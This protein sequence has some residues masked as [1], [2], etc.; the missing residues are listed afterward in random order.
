MPLLE[1][2]AE[3]LAR[4][5]SGW[6][7]LLKATTPF[8]SPYLA[9]LM[10]DEPQPE[11]MEDWWQQSLTN[12]LF[13]E[14][15]VSG[16]TLPGDVYSGEVDPRSDET[17]RRA[18]DFAGLAP[19][20]G[21]VAGGR[22]AVAGANKLFGG[23][24]G[25]FTTQ[26]DDPIMAEMEML[27][28]Q[29]SEPMDEVPFISGHSEYDKLIAA[30]MKEN[31]GIDLPV[32]QNLG[33][34]ALE[35]LDII[36]PSFIEGM[37]KHGVDMNL[38]KKQ[39]YGESDEWLG[40]VDEAG[41]ML[42]DPYALAASAGISES[43]VKKLED[44]LTPPDQDLILPITGDPAKDAAAA[45]FL[46]NQTAW[47]PEQKA[48]VVNSWTDAQW[49]SVFELTGMKSK[50]DLLKPKPL[51]TEKFPWLAAPA[52]PTFNPSL[53]RFSPEWGA[54][55]R[56]LYLRD[57]P[58]D[59]LHALTMAST[60]EE[61][62]EITERLMSL[63]PPDWQSPKLESDLVVPHA[64]DKV[65]QEQ[66]VL[67][68][69]QMTDPEARQRALD[70]G[71]DVNQ[72]LFRGTRYPAAGFFPP[73]GKGLEVAGF[74]T[75]RPDVAR[76]YGRYIYPLHMRAENPLERDFGGRE[77]GYGEWMDDFI[78]EAL[79][80]G[81]DAAVARNMRDKVGEGSRLQTQWMYFDPAQLRS[82]LAQFDPKKRGIN[83][84]LAAEAF[85]FNPFDFL[86]GEETEPRR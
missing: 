81:H 11:S 29:L 5:Q 14:P 35:N 48:S 27:L 22:G 13:V 66:S 18:A 60:E 46:E 77:Y 7:E 70:M 69:I 56:E 75:D 1:A 2:W 25:D 31:P 61:R 15:T 47:T 20:G 26:A 67:N 39:L 24:A 45:K 30:I 73:S 62:Q 3:G 32:A 63:L 68:N 55:R 6:K 23:L 42:D 40:V 51:N 86:A 80:G 57:E 74:L 17:I 44:T 54:I 71:F 33:E 16:L 84:L 78:N 21:L 53:N 4:P 65:H 37:A 83:N 43:V 64:W 58:P 59:D 10:G 52:T 72:L 79:A 36:A 82:P 28:K 76:T 8:V 9:P 12:Q 38:A 50:D 34:T 85:G 49:K 19:V 41:E